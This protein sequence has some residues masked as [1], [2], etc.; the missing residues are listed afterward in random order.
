MGDLFGPGGVFESAGVF[1]TGMT[2]QLFQPGTLDQFPQLNNY[3]NVAQTAT[4]NTQ[5]QLNQVYAQL[6]QMNEDIAK[7]VNSNI[8]AL[9]APSYD[10]SKLTPIAQS[11]VGKLLDTLVKS[12]QIQ[13]SFNTNDLNT[14]IADAIKQT[15]DFGKN[16]IDQIT[17]SVINNLG[18]I[19]TA[20]NDATSQIKASDILKNIDTSHNIITDSLSKMGTQAIQQIQDSVTKQIQ[21]LTSAKPKVIDIAAQWA[22]PATMNISMTPITPVAK[23]AV[24]VVA[25]AKAGGGYTGGVQ[26]PS[27]VIRPSG[28]FDITPIVLTPK[29]AAIKETN[30]VVG[31]TLASYTIKHPEM[32]GTEIAKKFGYTNSDEIGNVARNIDLARNPNVEYSGEAMANLNGIQARLSTD[33]KVYQYMQTPSRGTTTP[34]VAEFAPAIPTTAESKQIQARENT[35]TRNISDYAPDTQAMVKSLLGADVKTFSWDQADAKYIA[36]QNRADQAQQK[37]T[38]QSAKEEED[39]HWMPAT[40]VTTQKNLLEATI[41]G[42]QE[43]GAAIQGGL[44]KIGVGKYIEKIEEPVPNGPWTTIAKG[45]WDPVIQEAQSLFPGTLFTS[46]EDRLVS[47]GNLAIQI[48]KDDYNKAHEL[49]AGPSMP[50]EAIQLTSVRTRYVPTD[51]GLANIKNFASIASDPTQ[52]QSLN[53]DQKTLILDYADKTTLDNIVNKNPSFVAENSNDL[54]IATKVVD[55]FGADNVNTANTAAPVSDARAAQILGISS[56]GL[57]NLKDWVGSTGI[58]RVTGILPVDIALALAIGTGTGLESKIANIASDLVESK[59][60]PAAEGAIRA[61]SDLKTIA[62]KYGT[63]MPSVAAMKEMSIAVPASMVTGDVGTEIAKAAIR[64]MPSS[65]AMMMLPKTGGIALD[66]AELGG[67]KINENVAKS[68]LNAIG[69]HPDDNIIGTL[70]TLQK[71]DPETAASVMAEIQVTNPEL[72]GK[73]NDALKTGQFEYQVEKT[74]PT[75]RTEVESSLAQGVGTPG[76]ALAIE[77]EKALSEADNLAAVD[78]M[79]IPKPTDF[80]TLHVPTAGAVEKY[81][82]TLTDAQ[83]GALG[84]I[85]GT[86]DFALDKQAISYV[87]GLAGR[88]RGDPAQIARELIGD[89]QSKG[90]PVVESM[91]NRV[92]TYVPTEGEL[93]AKEM[94]TWNK[95]ATQL[96]NGWELADKTLQSTMTAEAKATGAGLGSIVADVNA[97][98]YAGAMDYRVGERLHGLTA[99]DINPL[100]MTMPGGGKTLQ[101]L[102]DV[103]GISDD[104][105][106]NVAKALKKAGLSE[107]EY[108]DETVGKPGLGVWKTWTIDE[109]YLKGVRTKA[110]DILVSE[111]TGYVAISRPG[112]TVTEKV[113]EQFLPQVEMKPLEAK[114]EIKPLAEDDITKIFLE[115]KPSIQHVKVGDAYKEV[116]TVKQMDFK[117]IETLIG[118]KSVEEKTVKTWMSDAANI[119]AEILKG[120]SSKGIIGARDMDWYKAMTPEDQAYFEKAVHNMLLGPLTENDWAITKNMLSNAKQDWAKVPSWKTVMYHKGELYDNTRIAD[121]LAPIA[122]DLMIDKTGTVVDGPGAQFVKKLEAGITQSEAKEEAVLNIKDIVAMEGQKQK[123]ID[124]A[125]A[126]DR[127]VQKNQAGIQ[128]GIVNQL[129]TATANTATVSEIQKAQ[130]LTMPQ[131]MKQINELLDDGTIVKTYKTVGGKQ[132]EAGYMLASEVK[133]TTVMTAIITPPNADKAIAALKGLDH[134]GAA[135][136]IR[137]WNAEVMPNVNLKGISV[138][139][140]GELEAHGVPSNVVEELRSIRQIQAEQSMKSKGLGPTLDALK[141]GKTP[142]AAG[143]NKIFASQ[144]SRIE[145]M[146]ALWGAEGKKNIYQ[147]KLEDI[148][149][150]WGETD[151]SNKAA[152]D[153]ITKEKDDFLKIAQDDIKK[154]ELDAPMTGVCRAGV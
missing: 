105:I 151:S 81:T 40:S 64:A 95:M 72:T 60:L 119:E 134:E 20:K 11:D 117:N 42:F 118:D 140:I 89:I 58:F 29:A 10:A 37:L 28:A 19:I 83:K 127:A 133:P 150:R 31:M 22:K 68:T 13:T 141:S 121:M 61:I 75:L 124:T 6:Q 32:S 139:S 131:A 59:G 92:M 87:Q 110:N 100:T 102:S 25:A 113:S 108:Y 145:A 71:S 12:G 26:R 112:E 34:K 30:D 109:D 17:S 52:F 115:R 66:A 137:T 88:T 49:S 99:T 5:N 54:A 154:C 27:A 107:V 96:T 36:L 98:T 146:D 15:S 84:E 8:A 57:T 67:M 47:N 21:D 74:G 16:A 142:D 62:A 33:G 86:S 111:R 1:G 79:L 44:D 143:L 94:E 69:N 51:Q 24:N 50:E 116:D 53:N 38:I 35:A 114:L 97:M 82:I 63:E 3:V 18:T 78:A 135:T 132:K 152:V 85:L 129:T 128:K 43:V 144:D 90:R 147:A 104:E 122:N 101:S 120:D 45:I 46:S 153:A 4:Q 91:V 14:S 56:E 70:I 77:G 130:G 80:E 48:N 9:I 123:A 55:R 93:T 41:G 65:E 126:I 149:G 23:E 138:N 2:G 103:A 39:S 76:E 73:I 7:K 125:K 106:S 148:I 136:E